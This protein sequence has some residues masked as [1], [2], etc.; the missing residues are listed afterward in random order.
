MRRS[1]AIIGHNPDK[2]WS[3]SHLVLGLQRGHFQRSFPHKNSVRIFS[4]L[5]ETYVYCLISKHVVWNYYLLKVN[6]KQT[7]N[8]IWVTSR[9][10]FSYGSAGCL[11]SPL[12]Y[13][14]SLQHK[15]NLK[16]RTGGNI[17][18]LGHRKLFY[19]TQILQ[20]ETRFTPTV[21]S[22]AK[23]ETYSLERCSTMTRKGEQ[24]L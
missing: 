22:A 5:Q 4:M 23:W 16:L 18:N 7:S 1:N 8:N 20:T 6:K 19:F 11:D 17:Q 9:Y 21:T 12:V 3:T 10:N 14:I 13:L 15:T 2:V 24:G